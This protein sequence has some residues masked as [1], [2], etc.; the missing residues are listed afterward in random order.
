MH[1]DDALLTDLYCLTMA[2]DY[3][4]EATADD[5]VTFEL[6]ARGTGATTVAGVEE[7]LGF[8][9]AMRF[10]AGD[11]RWLAEQDRVTF[12]EPVLA[13]L[14]DL[15]FA[16][17]VW[18]PREGTIVPAGTPLL[19][20]TASRLQ[21]TLVE[22]P[23][24]AAIN[25]ALR[26][27]TNAT[28]IVRAA[29]GRPVWDFSMRRLDGLRAGHTAARAA[30]LAGF[31]GTATVAAARDLAIPLTGTMAHAK[32]M[33]RGRAGELDVFCDQLR[34]RPAGA[35]LLVDTYDPL[36]GVH[37]AIAAQ[38]L[39]GARLRAIRI[40]SGDHAAL[41]A[42]ARA[43]LDEAGLSETQ[44]IL[45]GDLDAAQISALVA[46]DVPVDAF[47]VGTRLRSGEAIGAIYKLVEQP[48]EDDLALRYTMKI[49]PGK[50]T[51]PGAHQ[52]TRR[53]DGSHVLHLAGEQIAGVPL[54][55]EV[56][57]DGARTSRAPDLEA[58]RAHA[59][60]ER[61]RIGPHGPSALVRSPRLLA[62][63]E[64]DIGVALLT[65]NASRTPQQVAEWL[66]GMG[67]HV[68]PDEVV[69]SPIAAAAMIAP[70]TRCLVIGSDGLRVALDQRG[71]RERL[72]VSAGQTTWLE[73]AC[74]E[75]NATLA[76]L[77]S[78]V[79]PGGTAAAAQLHVCR[80]VCR[81]AERRALLVEDANPEVV[82]YLNRLSDLL[83]ILSR[84]ANDGEEP[85][86][87]PGRSQS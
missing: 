61:E 2:A 23:L 50:A 13:R 56:M 87:E 77:R 21:A 20:V 62:L 19:R 86:W 43:L 46:R 17:S 16:G 6:S 51:D 11:L 34:A 7:A 66:D 81:R 25:Y 79:L 26:V 24:L 54:L 64:R 31:A 82:R 9:E 39:T 83:F 32:V 80:T 59:A 10:S 68:T 63:R 15:R 8:L 69:T 14:A 78:F 53:A 49:S 48:G 4:H 75:V 29:A 67:I 47:G 18:A 44:I 55:A 73:G 12:D 72:R 35:T 3:V 57:R 41:A 60:A 27:A 38:R 40:D 1:P 33:A 22:T 5:V 36:D 76:P 30:Y 45:S 42:T 84:G 37:K 85:L 70:G 28:A 74:D 65:N 58:D 71:D 52:V